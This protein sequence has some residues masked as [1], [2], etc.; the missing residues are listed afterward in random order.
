VEHFDR[1][2]DLLRSPAAQGL[3]DAEK[4]AAME[5]RVLEKLGDTLSTVGR[6]GDAAR[7]F[8]SLAGS[9]QLDD[10]SA[11]RVRRRLGAVALKRA[12]YG[13]ATRWLREALERVADRGP[14]RRER[15]Q[16]LQAMARSN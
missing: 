13:T 9:Q 6:Y 1:V 3:L 16:V 8:E 10:E 15:A 4:R 5:A 7:V 14:L 2:I 12:D 11:A